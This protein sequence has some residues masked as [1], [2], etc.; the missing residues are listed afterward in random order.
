MLI[1]LFLPE[2]VNVRSPITGTIT[3]LHVQSEK[4]VNAGAILAEIGNPELADS[5][6]EQIATAELRL[7]QVRLELEELESHKP[8]V[9]TT[10]QY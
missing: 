3:K 4:E 1:R 8:S 6:E 7:K 2:A 10:A 9:L 5:L